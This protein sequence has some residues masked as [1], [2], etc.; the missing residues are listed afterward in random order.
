MKIRDAAI[1]LG[2]L[3]VTVV[4]FFGAIEVALRVTGIVTIKPNPPRIYQTS[5]VPDIGYEL[6]PNISERAYRSTVTTNGLGFRSAELDPAKPTLAFLGDS[7]TFGYGLED[8][9]TIPAHVAEKLPTWN[10]LNTAAP[11]Y[12]LIQQTATYREKVKQLNPR[13]FVLIFHFNDVEEVGLE[14]G[15]L[16]ADGIL[17]PHGWTPEDA[18]CSPTKKGILGMIP[19]K[20]WLDL[21][22]ALYKAVKKYANTRQGQS[23]REETER[24]ASA[25]LYDE[26]VTPQNLS[27]YGEYLEKLRMQLPPDVPRLFVIW[28]ERFLHFVARPQLRAIAEANGFRVLDLYEIF[29]NRAETLGWDS[30]HPSAETAAAGSEAI[31]AALEHFKMLT[32]EARLNP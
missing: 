28:P 19:G 18:L 29:G 20:C 12:N 13:A 25:N 22:S 10:V 27:R 5:A 15:Q 26:N 30:V 21:H 14:L 23:D 7:I 9:E 3:F 2:L 11:G 24:T 6:K 16:D 31:A 32:P 1:N 4:L 8:H 17:R